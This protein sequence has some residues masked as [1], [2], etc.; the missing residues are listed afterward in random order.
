MGKTRTSDEIAAY[1]AEQI[2]RN[3]GDL[4]VLTVQQFVERIQPVIREAIREGTKTELKQAE[5]ARARA[6][7]LS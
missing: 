4:R 3:C 2:I 5:E 1:A 6:N 7:S